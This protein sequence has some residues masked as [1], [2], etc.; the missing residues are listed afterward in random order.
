MPPTTA[1]DVDHSDEG[2]GYVP[3][4]R[5]RAERR[6]YAWVADDGT[7]PARLV[8]LVA[9]FAPFGFAVAFSVPVCPS[10]AAGIPCPGCGLT[11]ATLALL[12]GDVAAATA[13]QPLALVVCPLLG[14]AAAY[15]CLRYLVTGKV[16]A[17]RWYAGPILVVSMVALTIVWTLR[18]FGYFGG[19]VP[20]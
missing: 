13:L 12:Q 20:V 18:W 10:A 3:Y 1:P 9:L 2:G 15:A 7:V 19:P 5:S 11:R 6:F 17:D 4:F 14:G 16:Q 8:R